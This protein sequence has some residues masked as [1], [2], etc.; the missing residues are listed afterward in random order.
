MGVVRE[1]ERAS[2]RRT[3]QR[4]EEGSVRA[5]IASSERGSACGSKAASNGVMSARESRGVDL[6]TRLCRVAP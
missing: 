3:P 6:A 2:E 5:T 4:W 1:R